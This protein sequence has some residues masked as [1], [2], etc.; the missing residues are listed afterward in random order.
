MLSGHQKCRYV[1]A[2]NAL[3]QYTELSK[4]PK[5]DPHAKDGGGTLANARDVSQGAA[6]ASGS[7]RVDAVPTMVLPLADV[8]V[9]VW[10]GLGCGVCV[11]Q[12]ESQCV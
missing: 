4:D 12:P 10:G 3:Y 9:C 5:A 6:A 8:E 2:N 11:C 1:L 7:D